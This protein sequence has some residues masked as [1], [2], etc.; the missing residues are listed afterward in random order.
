MTSTYI[1]PQQKAPAEV[2]WDRALAQ[3]LKPAR[4][5]HHYSQRQLGSLINKSLSTIRSYEDGIRRPDA[6]TLLRLA[7]IL[8]LDLNTLAQRALTW[9]LPQGHSKRQL[10]LPNT[11]V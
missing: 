5:R 9:G 8:K 7:V 3:V 6:R 4:V 10:T 1:N 11:D 2:E